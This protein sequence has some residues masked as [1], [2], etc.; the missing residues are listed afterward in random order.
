MICRV[1]RQERLFPTLPA[2]LNHMRLVHSLIPV[3][4]DFISFYPLDEKQMQLLQKVK[5]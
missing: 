2:Y 1:C 3:G 4:N 5:S